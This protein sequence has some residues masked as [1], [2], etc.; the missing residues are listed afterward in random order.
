MHENYGRDLDLNLLRVFVVVAEA[1]GVTAAAARLYLT[2]PAVSAAL[3]RLR[4]TV[5]APLLARRGRGLVLTARGQRLLEQARPHLDGLVT[6]AL[7]PPAFEPLT[8]TRTLRL[9]LSDSA[10]SWLLPALLRDLALRAPHMRVVSLP[11][12]FRTIERALESQRLDAAVTVA[13]DLPA[14]TER[15]TLFQKSFVVLGD[16][17]FAKL[18]RRP[19]LER[20][21]AHAHAIVSYNGDMR[22]IVED[23]LG[24]ERRVRCSVA[25]FAA[26]ADIIEGTPLLATVPELVARNALRHH[27]HLRTWPVPFSL[28]GAP[29]ELVWN[30]ALD[31]DACSFLRTA[32]VRVVEQMAD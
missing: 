12:Q 29:L 13:D 8:S 30:R 3:K 24:V 15:R 25:S 9:G 11:V 19:T 31:D 18:G 17:R 6:A 5:G 21:L 26:L 7:A 20:Y 23:M 27:R 28:L 22:G 2:Q 10:E 14:G 16:V 32:I 1:G 4:H